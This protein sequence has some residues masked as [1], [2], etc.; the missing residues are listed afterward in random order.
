VER[1]TGTLTPGTSKTQA[2]TTVGQTVDLTFQGIEGQQPG[3]L[4]PAASL[5]R[6]GPWPAA[7]AWR[8]IRPDGSEGDFGGGFTSE[9]DYREGRPLDATGTWT[10]RIVPSGDTTGSVT[11]SLFLATDRTATATVGT[12]V[13]LELAAAQNAH[14]AFTAAAGR[15]VTVRVLSSTLA[16]ATNPNAR[17]S[18]GLQGPDGSFLAMAFSDDNRFA[19]TEFPVDVA[20]T[21]RLRV[22]P[23]GAARGT[24]RL[25]VD[26]PADL[27]VV[28]SFTS[29][30]RVALPTPGRNAAL[31]ITAAA[32]Q[33][34]TVTETD[35]TWTR[36]DSTGEPRLGDVGYRLR[37]PDGG[38]PQWL[39]MADGFADSRP[40]AVSGTWTLEVDPEADTTG[41]ATLA[42]GVARDVGGPITLGTPTTV[43]LARGETARY[44]FEGVA[45]RV[46]NVLV[47][48]SGW[49]DPFRDVRMTLVGPRTS[50]TE[51]MPTGTTGGPGSYVE[52]FR[53][54]DVS[55]TWTLVIDPDGPVSGGPRRSR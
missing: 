3:M 24:L 40:L 47:T 49:S 1:V 8:L 5:T 17:A 6:T 26:Q 55:G 37:P 50:G 45:G 2:L 41:S 29:P 10:L 51:L 34:L 19:E 53:P 36:A 16:T 13:T 12:P 54:L 44:T 18:F 15:R 33:R 20:G 30:T 11:F 39:S 7:A 48:S 14:V 43:T 31:R 28:A 27:E 4:A 35:A 22:D 21:W 9:P 46:P 42:L 38:D 23:Y 52:A 32:G 25:Q